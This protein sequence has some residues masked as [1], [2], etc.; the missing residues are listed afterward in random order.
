MGPGLLLKVMAGDKFKAGVKGW[1]LPGSTNADPLP[2]AS[3]IVSSLVTAFTGGLSGIAGHGTGGS[4]PGSTELT[5]PLQ[6][7]VTGNNNSAGSGIPK[8]YLNWVLLDDE[9]FQLVEG[10]FGAIPMPQIS[11]TE[12][13]K[14]LA[15]N[16]GNDIEILRNGYL[17]VYVSNESQGNVYFDDLSVTHTR[18][19]L[20]EESHYYPFGLQMA[21]ISG[22]SLNFGDPANKYKFNGKEEQQGEFADGTGLEWLDYGSRMYDN[23]VGRF[24]NQDR[25]AHKYSSLTPY[26]YTANNPILFTDVNGDSLIVNSLPGNTTAVTTYEKQ[27]NDGLGGFY[28]LGKSSTGRYVLNATSQEGEMNAEQQ[29]F[30]NTMQETISHGTD[31]TFTAIDANDAMAQ[32]VPIADNGHAVDAQG[33]NYS[34]QPGT[35]FIDVGDISNFSAT[36]Y[37]SAQSIIGHE[38]K[39]GFEIQTKGLTTAAQMGAAHNT[40]IATENSI[41]GYERGI[42]PAGDFANNTLTLNLNIP[43]AIPNVTIPVSVAATINNNQVTNVTGNTKPPAFSPAT[44]FPPKFRKL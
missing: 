26:H 7:F 1:Y 17:Y 13:R 21:G 33:T 23:Q 22:K 16:G 3:N 44:L 10:N 2:G 24:F 20:L 18:G 42:N 41:G 25:F 28:T 8:A 35:H 14:A 5:G 6:A 29:A 4:T 27:V 34:A 40:A 31:V 38:T 19:A 43:S 30:Y 39:E 11:G 12:E 15:A 36:G 9:Q 32:N 37:V